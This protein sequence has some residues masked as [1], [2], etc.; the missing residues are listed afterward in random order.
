MTLSDTRS[1]EDGFGSCGSEFEHPVQ[2][3]DGESDFCRLRRV[4][5]SSRSAADHLLVSVEGALDSFLLVIAG[6]FLP[7]PHA[8]FPDGLYCLVSR[9]CC[10]RVLL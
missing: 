10:A 4:D 7:F 5:S 8:D 2:H 6:S 3:V 1:V 9:A